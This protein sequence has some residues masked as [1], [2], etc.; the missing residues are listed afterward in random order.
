LPGGGRR[1]NDVIELPRIDYVLALLDERR[2]NSTGQIDQLVSCAA[3]RPGAGWCTSQ[4]YGPDFVQTAGHRGYGQAREG[5]LKQLAGSPGSTRPTGGSTREFARL[6]GD[7]A[8]PHTCQGSGRDLALYLVDLGGLGG[9]LSSSS[10]SPRTEPGGVR[11]PAAP[12]QPWQSPPSSGRYNFTDQL[13]RPER[14]IVKS[15]GSGCPD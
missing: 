10:C 12:G 8:D 13:V 4:F 3:V 9:P 14:G 1:K 5:A 6:A 2:D 15:C 11:S 7:C